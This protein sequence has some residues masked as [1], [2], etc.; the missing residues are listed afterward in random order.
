MGLPREDKKRGRGGGGG[1]ADGYRLRLQ[2]LLTRHSHCSGL[3]TEVLANRFRRTNEVMRS[4]RLASEGTSWEE[5]PAT[6]ATEAI[7]L[8]LVRWTL[9]SAKLRLGE[10]ASKFKATLRPAAYLQSKVLPQF[11]PCER[12]ACISCQSFESSAA[13]NNDIARYGTASPTAFSKRNP[14]DLSQASSCLKQEN[15]HPLPTMA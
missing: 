13:A 14:R 4:L 10:A 3:D 7:M 12:M 6:G 1:D 8:G 15:S 9:R 2:D 5:A 11:T